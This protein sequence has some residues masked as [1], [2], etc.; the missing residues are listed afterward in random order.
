MKKENV[1]VAYNAERLSAIKLFL[2][3]KNLDFN[4]EMES[5]LDS[6]FKKVVPID[7]RRFLDM[8]QDGAPKK[9][10]ATTGKIGISKLKAE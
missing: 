4:S 8:K 10:C 7:V 6:L 9:P 2:A 3:Q 1:T 5:F